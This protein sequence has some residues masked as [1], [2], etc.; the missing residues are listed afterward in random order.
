MCI[1]QQPFVKKYLG[2]HFEP[3]RVFKIMRKEECFGTIS[4]SLQK[5]PIHKSSN[6][7]DPMVTA[8]I[9]YHI[10]GDQWQNLGQLPVFLPPRHINR[11]VNC[12]FFIDKITEEAKKKKKSASF[13]QNVYETRGSE[14]TLCRNSRD[15]KIGP[16][17]VFLLKC[18]F[19]KSMLHK[20]RTKRRK[21]QLSIFYSLIVSTFIPSKRLE[22]EGGGGN[23]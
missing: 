12:F 14:E 13:L 18:I 8:I 4:V 20:V 1:F 9:F 5:M 10:T 7:F 6:L 17:T 19:Q 3:T 11:L 16:P 15:C 23:N 21:V 22:K 2:D